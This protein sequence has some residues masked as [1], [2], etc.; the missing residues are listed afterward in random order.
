[1]EHGRSGDTPVA[2]VRWGTKPEQEVLTGTLATI[3]QLVRERNFQAP[4]IIIVGEVVQLREQLRWFDSRPLFGKRVVVT[5]ARAQ[6]S[7]L[8]ALLEEQGADC[9]Q[10]PTIAIR[11]MDEYT[12]L[13]QAIAELNTYQWVVFT[14]VNGVEHFYKRLYLT[15][16]DSRALHTA[17]IA[18]IGSQ[19]A[20][21][22]AER[23]IQ[24]D[25]VPKEFRAEGLLE[26]FGAELAGV[27]I[28]I[29]RAE[30]ARELLP[31]ELGKRGAQVNVAP[32]Y[33][34]IIEAEEAAS[35]IDA[36]QKKQ[37]DAVTFTSSSTVKNFLKML[38]GQDVKAVMQGVLVAAIGPI[39]VD[40][41]KEAGLQVDVMAEEYTVRGLTEALVSALGNK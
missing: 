17:K 25:F 24:A 18:A 33:R 3:E 19:T 29:P 13:D 1:M 5:R 36:L 15:G 40:T 21:A 16:K 14:S 32:T 10:C 22:L 9:L 11:E 7:D 6:A 8:I 38:E 23:G 37:V 41:A 20:A 28:L 34:T 39:T 30:E 31:E 27:R 35:L 12:V 26:G 2:V 4:A